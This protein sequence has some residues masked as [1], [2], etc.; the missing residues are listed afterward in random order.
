MSNWYNTEELEGIKYICAYCGAIVSPNKG[1]TTINNIN[2]TGELICICPNCDKPTYKEYDKT[3]P[4]P[5]RGMDISGI[6]D[7][8]LEKLYDEAR[9]TFQVSAYTSCILCCRKA[10][11][12][13]AVHCGA[14]ENLNFIQYIN[15]LESNGY[16]P[17]NGREWVDKIRTLG[18]EA[19]HEII[20]SSEKDAELAITFLGML[21]KFIYEMPN[22][23]EKF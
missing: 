6:N 5:K 10:L 21:L 4:S 20:I 1:Y 12:H 23:L 2:I 22:M 13:I 3:Y 17:P 9:R 16:I 8:E 19:T 11:M 18:N 15:H 7:L 14:D